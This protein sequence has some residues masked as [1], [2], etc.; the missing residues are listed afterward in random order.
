[1]FSGS[2]LRVPLLLLLVPFVLCD[3]VSPKPGLKRFREDYKSIAETCQAV[4]F[5]KKFTS[6]ECRI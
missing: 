2:F 6:K 4:G 5:T 1:M 3:K